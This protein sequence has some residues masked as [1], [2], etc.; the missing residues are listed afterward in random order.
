MNKI[1]LLS[2]MLLIS[3]ISLFGQPSADKPFNVHKTDL[4][5]VIDGYPDDV[6]WSI[7][8]VHENTY[9]AGNSYTFPPVPSDFSVSWQ[10]VWNETGL[11]LFVKIKDDVWNPYPGEGNT[12][13]Y[14]NVEVY[15]YFG[16]DFGPDA[17]VTAVDG[18]EYFNQIRMQLNV[19]DE[20][21]H[22]GRIKGMW[23]ALFIGKAPEELEFRI[24]NALIGEWH[25][26]AIIPWE[27]ISTKNAV[28]V[29]M[30]FGLEFQGSDA[31]EDV[32]D[33]ISLFMN[34]TGSDLAW[35][36][37]AYLC[38]ATLAGPYFAVQEPTLNPIYNH[39]EIENG[40]QVDLG[41]CR[42]IDTVNF[43][44]ILQNKGT[45]ALDISLVTLD[46]EGFDLLNSAK[47][48]LN[49]F[50]KDTLNLQVISNE[51]KQYT[52]NLNIY[53]SDPNHGNFAIPILIESVDA[54]PY[55]DIEVSYQG[56][57]VGNAT[58]ID[59]G[60]VIVDSTFVKKDIIIKNRGLEELVFS[61]ISIGLF[62]NL[63]TVENEPDILKFGE[64][65]VLS[66]YFKPIH[67]YT[68]RDFISDLEIYCNDPENEKITV[69]LK[70]FAVTKKAELAVK[71]NEKIH[72]VEFI[73]HLG[74]KS[75][76]EGEITNQYVLTNIG[77]NNIDSIS[78]VAQGED[79]T[80]WIAGDFP[81]AFRDTL[82]L[83]V[84][85]TPQPDKHSTGYI[86]LF[87]K[88]PVGQ[89]FYF[90]IDG[91]GINAP[92]PPTAM[93][94]LG[95]KEIQNLTDTLNFGWVS[96]HDG[97]EQLFVNIRNLGIEPLNLQTAL[98]SE[99]FNIQASQT[100]LDTLWSLD[101]DEEKML[102]I[103]FTPDE[104]TDYSD[105]LTFYTNDPQKDT[106]MIPLTGTGVNDFPTMLVN[107]DGNN[108]KN[109]IDTLYFGFIDQDGESRRK[110]I[111]VKNL[112]LD[113]LHGLEYSLDGEGFTVIQP[114][115]PVL[116]FNQMFGWEIEFKP[117]KTGIYKGQL[118]LQ[119]NDP[120]NSPFIMH[121]LG[122]ADLTVGVDNHDPLKFEV[123]P[124]PAENVIYINP[125]SDAE[126]MVEIY[127]L[128]GIRLYEER[129]DGKVWIDISGF[130]SGVYVMKIKTMEGNW[131]RKI[132][133][134]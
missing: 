4:P 95:S 130:E 28:Q 24:N 13:Q 124:N 73:Q 102:L 61:N 17:E 3:S 33:A 41:Y 91:I 44:I 110:S 18:D 49:A 62:S 84:K 65:K 63:F 15:L 114:Y 6:I 117:E 118:Q 30:Q 58:L 112:G 99:S 85:Y 69:G 1:S 14:D 36:N 80:A 29:G 128:S 42:A 75:V 105:L 129:Y 22:D 68:S 72:T 56:E 101:L 52:A 66:V 31:D 25:L 54:P 21:M 107:A 59:F 8:P 20:L 113:Y 126:Y 103:T 23:D 40:E 37:K 71:Q 132:V 81:L 92:Q 90:T 60:N 83:N 67:I 127:T 48:S 32:R 7:A 94:S 122:E 88:F 27:L 64:S 79:F 123:Y 98:E 133:K 57:A 39:A 26:E 120:V 78:T 125:R 86:S 119:S 87:Y 46:G 131:L 5:V 121:L 50:E 93:F 51:I 38:T 12:Y 100:N 108:L 47:N 134:E 70:G 16:D 89:P 106:F 45:E 9:W 2:V 104:T 53:S 97:V 19:D 35:N 43:D 111:M 96:S 82:L 55:P 10:L 77:N 109:G 74:K 76:F 11:I 34:D 116:A 115:Y